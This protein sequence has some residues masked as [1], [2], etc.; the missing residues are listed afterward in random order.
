M[1]TFQ[2]SFLD[3]SLKRQIL[4][5]TWAGIAFANY[6]LQNQL[7]GGFNEEGSFGFDNCFRSGIVQRISG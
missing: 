7:R 4:D 5:D 2:M 1:F 6:E 3:D